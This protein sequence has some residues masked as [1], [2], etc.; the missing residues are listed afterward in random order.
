LSV[1]DQAQLLEAALHYLEHEL[2]GELEGEHRFK[3][4]L[5][6]NALRIVQREHLLFEPLSAEPEQA[7][8]LAQRLRAGNIPLNDPQLLQALETRLAKALAIN[9]PKWIHKP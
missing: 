2:L 6:I 4:R 1:P 7:L 9:N 8:E 3:T 5:A